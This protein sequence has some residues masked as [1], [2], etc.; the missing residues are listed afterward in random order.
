MKKRI[1]FNDPLYNIF[2][3]KIRDRVRLE[4]KYKTFEKISKRLTG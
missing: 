4:I 1:Q 3:P 2:Y